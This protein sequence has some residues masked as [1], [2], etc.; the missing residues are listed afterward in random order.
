VAASDQL[1]EWN[2]YKNSKLL[3]KHEHLTG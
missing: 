2:S 3:V 1:G